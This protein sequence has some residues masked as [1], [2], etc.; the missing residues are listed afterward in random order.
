ML[1]YIKL[2]FDKFLRFFFKKLSG[3]ININYICT[4]CEGTCLLIVY[5]IYRRTVYIK[6][7]ISQAAGSGN[8]CT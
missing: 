4:I 8:A 5:I 2:E 6:R 3:Y 7:G 1:F